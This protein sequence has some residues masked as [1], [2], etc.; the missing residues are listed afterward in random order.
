MRTGRHDEANNRFLELQTRLT[1][2]RAPC[3]FAHFS[4]GNCLS[5]LT[6]R[7]QVPRDVM[8]PPPPAHCTLPPPVDHTRGFW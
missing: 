8:S 6:T 2:H 4:V 5:T 1:M 7:I 3:H